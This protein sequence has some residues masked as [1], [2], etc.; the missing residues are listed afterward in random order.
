MLYYHILFQDFRLGGTSVAPISQIHA[1]VMLL[2]LIAVTSG[3]VTFILSIRPIGRLTQ[4]LRGH[5]D[6]HADS[7]SLLSVLK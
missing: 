6:T 3:G 2:L 7:T 1:S 5:A 4:K